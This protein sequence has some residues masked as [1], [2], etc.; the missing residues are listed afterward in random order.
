MSL[1]S[2]CLIAWSM[3]WLIRVSCCSCSMDKKRGGRGESELML[4]GG[5]EGP[6]DQSVFAKELLPSE[7]V[8][9]HKFAWYSLCGT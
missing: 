7:T 2:T 9:V 5:D 6:G 3:A 1:S 4:G 8:V